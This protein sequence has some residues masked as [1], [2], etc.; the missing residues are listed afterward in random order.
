MILSEY[1]HELQ[2][3]MAIRNRYFSHIR[4]IEDVVKK[5]GFYIAGRTEVAIQRLC[6]AELIY[7]WHKEATWDLTIE[8]YYYTA[9]WEQYWSDNP[10]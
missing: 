9:Q 10:L 1:C 2:V 3:M 8:G 7:I 5:E 6:A 4:S